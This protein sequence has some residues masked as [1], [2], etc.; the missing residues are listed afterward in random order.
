VRLRVAVEIVDRRLG[1]FLN[2]QVFL[3]ALLWDFL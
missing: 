1:D 2:F 3:G